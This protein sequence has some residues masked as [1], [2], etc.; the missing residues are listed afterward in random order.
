MTGELEFCK[1]PPTVPDQVMMALLG[2][3]PVRLLLLSSVM[4]SLL[5]MELELPTAIITCGWAGI[6]TVSG[7]LEMATCGGGDSSLSPSASPV[8]PRSNILTIAVTAVVNSQVFFAGL[9]FMVLP[10][11]RAHAPLFPVQ[12]WP[13]HALQ[14]DRGSAVTAGAKHGDAVQLDRRRTATVLLLAEILAGR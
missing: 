8:M 1:P 11:R 7:M 12:S 9:R 10:L 2:G 3:R 4:S 13:V 5:S 14:H 6:T